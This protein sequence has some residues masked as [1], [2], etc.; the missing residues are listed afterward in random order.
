MPSTEKAHAEVAVQRGVLHDVLLQS[1]PANSVFP[2]H[3]CVNVELYE[4]SSSP[5]SKSGR[6]I[7][8]A[9][10]PRHRAPGDNPES[11]SRNRDNS[12]ISDEENPDTPEVVLTPFCFPSSPTAI[13]IFILFAFVVAPIN[14]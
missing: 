12:K 9:G 14:L 1:L 4:P 10:D 11:S 5:T 3:G 8:S 6:H 13:F 7:A 2:E